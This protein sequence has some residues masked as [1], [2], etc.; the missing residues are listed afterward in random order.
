MSIPHPS[1]LS[2]MVEDVTSRLRVLTDVSDERNRQ[3]EKFGEQDREN[4]TGSF[5]RTDAADAKSI[6]QS[7]PSD[8]NTWDEILLEEVYEALETE[9][10]DVENLRKELIQVAAVC[11]AWV[12]NLDRKAN[13]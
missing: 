9:P 1:T 5:Y 4:G 8:E 11:V 2:R 13:R 7:R 10:Q 6:C 12:E 3:I